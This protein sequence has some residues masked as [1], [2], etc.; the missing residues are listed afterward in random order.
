MYGLAGVPDTR[1]PAWVGCFCESGAPPP[2]WESP[3]AVT[4]GGTGCFPSSPHQIAGAFL[5]GG[6]G[7]RGLSSRPPH[8]DEVHC[9]EALLAFH[10]W[11]CSNVHML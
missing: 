3:V 1:R 11:A 9:E 5:E 4:T 6:S 10:V 2:D 7:K 8:N